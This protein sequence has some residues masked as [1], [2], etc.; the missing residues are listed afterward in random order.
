MTDFE[1]K[2]GPILEAVARYGVNVTKPQ[3]GRKL[4]P[5][6]A[7]KAI[8][9]LVWDIRRE[10]YLFM[11]DALMGRRISSDDALNELW[12]RINPPRKALRDE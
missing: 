8:S 1:K 4:H 7:I 2:L 5:G 12:A 10:D 9:Q 3:P 11:A 6:V